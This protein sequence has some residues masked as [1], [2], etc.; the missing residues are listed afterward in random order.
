MSDEEADQVPI[1][2]LNG[3]TAATNAASGSGQEAGG[4]AA[5]P[6]PQA[7]PEKCRSRCRSTSRG[8][9]GG[10]PDY[11]NEWQ[12]VAEVVDRLFFWTFLTGLIAISL[13][14]FHPLT[15]DYFSRRFDE[16]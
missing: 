13:L 3:T 2:V 6:V 15:K 7:D 8:E 12:I 4:A 1:I 10:M 11:S 5:Y 16:T 14:L 9:A